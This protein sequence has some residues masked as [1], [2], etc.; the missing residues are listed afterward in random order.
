[1]YF[2][3]GHEVGPFHNTLAFNDWVQLAALPGFPM[4]ERPPDPYRSLLPDKCSIYFTHG[5]LH[6]GNIIVSGTPGSR[7]VVGILDWEQAGWYP[8][9][10][11]Y[12]KLLIPGPCNHE[13]RE[14]GWADMIMANYEEGW[15]AFSAY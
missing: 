11:E 13:W 8:E 3:G 10:W 14:S 6:L 12:C 1:M 5:D 9:Y 7:K 2:R 15:I 4:S